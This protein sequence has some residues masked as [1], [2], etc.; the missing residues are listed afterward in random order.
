MRAD[1]EEEIRQVITE[2]VSSADFSD[3]DSSRIL[4]QIHSSM[5]ERRKIMR[6]SKKQAGLAAAA[7]LVILGSITAVGAGRI[8][9]LYS[10]TS[11][12]E[13]VTSYE[14]M[15]ARGTESLGK[16]PQMVEEFSGGQHFKRGFATMIDAADAAGQ[17]VGS[18][19][20]ISIEY[21]GAEE[22]NFSVSKPLEGVGHSAAQ[23][24]EEYEG[25]V[26]SGNKDQY[27]FLPPGEEPSEED[28]KLEA[29]GRL[30]ISYG[31]TAEERRVF[32]SVNWQEDGLFYHLYTYE[33]VSLEEMIGFAKEVIDS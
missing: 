18:Y 20:E 5:G 10:H 19:P 16:A 13:E 6:L 2:Q 23:V 32:T 1:W 31:S 22:L 7:A 29:E 11:L 17:M 30:Y 25:I 14:E 21:S 3:E 27:L 26:I 15:K 12:N 8:A 33:D 4:R 24:T 28:K 9:V